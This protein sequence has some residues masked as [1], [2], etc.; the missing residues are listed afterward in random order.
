MKINDVL[1]LAGGKGTRVKSRS[2]GLPKVLMKINK[3]PFIDIQVDWLKKQNIKN[4]YLLLKYKNSLIT[5][6]ILSKK[7]IDNINFFFVNEKEYLGTGGAIK[8]ALRY[9]KKNEHCLVVNGDT[10]FYKK[11]IKSFINYHLKNK[12]MLTIGCSLKKDIKRY[13]K[14]YTNGNILNRIDP[15]KGISESGYVYSGILIISPK[16]IQKFYLKEFSIERFIK[17]FSKKNKTFVFKFLSKNFFYDYG[18]E[19][20][21]DKV[22]KIGF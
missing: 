11:N 9:R 16:I 12:S 17:Y 3:R 2:K 5:K 10:F 14:V 15:P 1:I 6:Y 22:K 4:F 7:T 20:S 19:S 18:T 8:N 13:G 21:Y